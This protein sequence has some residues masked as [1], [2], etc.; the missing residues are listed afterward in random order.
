MGSGF[1]FVENGIKFDLDDRLIPK[2][3]FETV[4]YPGS[5]WSWGFNSF[6]ILVIPI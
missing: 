3:L 6:G 1:T 4:F 2:S 5:L